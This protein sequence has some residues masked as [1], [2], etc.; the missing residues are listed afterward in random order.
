MAFS[1]KLWKVKDVL[2]VHLKNSSNVVKKK[3]KNVKV[4][5]RY[6]NINLGMLSLS[7]Y[8]K[9]TI[10]NGIYFIVLMSTNEMDIDDKLKCAI[11]TLCQK[12]FKSLSKKRLKKNYVV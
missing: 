8:Y 2:L 7:I 6:F 5:L 11:L 1:Q 4:Q 3:N 9:I 12:V 10:T